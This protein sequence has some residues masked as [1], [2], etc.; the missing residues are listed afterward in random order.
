M[1]R[2]VLVTGA[3]GFIGDPTVWELAERGWRIRALVRRSSDPTRLPPEVERA[4]GDLRDYESL[5]RA[6]RGCQDVVHLAGLIRTPDPRQYDRVNRDGTA[7]IVR[8]C[9]DEGVERLL[10][11]SSLA[12]GGPSLS[13]RRRTMNDPDEPITAYGRSKLAGEEVLRNG[14]GSVWW[15]ALR[16][17][18]VY[19]PYDR[20]FL[21]YMRMINK[22]WKIR[23]GDGSM[24]FS[25]V[26]VADLARAICLALT[27]EGPSGAVRYVTDGADHTLHELAGLVEELLGRRARW[28]ALPRWAGMPVAT[29]AEFLSG[30]RVPA[31]LSRR[32]VLELLQP[33]WTCDDSPLRTEVGYSNEFDLKRGIRN[34]V[35]WYREEGWL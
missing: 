6:A 9:R 13:D 25:L 15:T 23:L 21:G 22:G 26:H 14:A 4:E 8:A 24:P 11:C 5:A 31:I 28:I 2:R 27:W 17:P 12:A 29:V 7:N 33:A 16:P 20:S 3:T 34:T 18:P 30:N 35:E 1:S 32:K 10:Y 19:G